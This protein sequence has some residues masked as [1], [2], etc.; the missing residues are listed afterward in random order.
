[1]L[2]ASHRIA[3]LS[4]RESNREEVVALSKRFGMPSKWTSWLAIPLAERANFKQQI[5]ASDRE[6]ASRGYAQRLRAAT[7][8]PRPATRRACKK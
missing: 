6:S 2:W 8:K 1:L 3:Q 5:L 4:A 7:A